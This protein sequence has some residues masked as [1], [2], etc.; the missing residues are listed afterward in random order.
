MSLFM[1]GYLSANQLGDNTKA[2]RIY[3]EFLEK[4]PDDELVSS[5]KFELQNIGKRPEEIIK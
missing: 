5:V 3:N 1:I 2:K 4:Y